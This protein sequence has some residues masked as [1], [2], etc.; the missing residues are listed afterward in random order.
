M[1]DIGKENPINKKKTAL[2][3]VVVAYK[4]GGDAQQG[5]SNLCAVISEYGTYSR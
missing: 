3:F 2:L 1:F 5:F 4:I